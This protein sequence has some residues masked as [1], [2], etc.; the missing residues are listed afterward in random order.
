MKLRTRYL[1]SVLLAAMLCFC[2]CRREI[3]E[4]FTEVGGGKFGEKLPE[5]VSAGR[6]TVRMPA[7]FVTGNDALE[8]FLT[9]LSGIVWRI[10]LIVPEFPGGE[11]VL[12]E[13]KR[14]AEQRFMLKFGGSEEVRL[15]GTV[16]RLS[17]AYE[18]GT[19][20]IRLSFIDRGYETVFQ[21]E[22]STAEAD[23]ARKIRRARTDILLLESA[24]EAFRKE[25]GVPPETLRQLVENPGLPQW[26]GPYIDAIA[27]DPWGRKFIYRR[28][29]GKFLLYSTGADGTG[30]LR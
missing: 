2:G 6:E 9:P 14:F 24:V 4:R 8:L 12:S 22:N 19:R 1:G 15:P 5:T 20:G 10:D 13:A 23:A 30:V 29:G 28:E 27:D 25:V 21:A 7:K 11:D 26:R 17:R 3:P 18:C 16:V